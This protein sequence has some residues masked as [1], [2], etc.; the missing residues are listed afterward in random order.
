MSD[1]DTWLDDL[2]LE[3]LAPYEYVAMAMLIGSERTPLR[4]RKS[5]YDI[6]MQRHNKAKQLI[7]TKMMEVI[8]EKKKMDAVVLELWHEH[9]GYNQAIDD[10]TKALKEKI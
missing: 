4:I 1:T 3:I 10:I 7:L 9:I 2:V 8:P 6:Y 5:G